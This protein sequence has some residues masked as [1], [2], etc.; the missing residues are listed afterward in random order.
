MLAISTR[1]DFG[2]VRTLGMVSYGASQKGCH[3]C[4][5]E[6]ARNLACIAPIHKVDTTISYFYIPKFCFGG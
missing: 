4:A 3:I 2:S 6:S 1:L 5:Q